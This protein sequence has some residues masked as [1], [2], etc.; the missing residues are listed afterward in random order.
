MKFFT[1]VVCWDEV[2][3]NVLDIEHSFKSNNIPHKIINSG[4]RI[5]DEWLNVGDIRY[6]RQLYKAVQDFDRSYEYMFWLAGDVS[7]NNWISFLDRANLSIS[8]YNVFAYAPHLTSEPWHEGSSRITNLDLDNKMLLSIQTDG[9][10]VI[11]HR[12]VVNML[13]KYFDFL[14][15]KTDITK[16]TSGWGMDMI[17]CAYSIYN[18]KLVL[19][20]NANILNHPSGSSYNHD[21]A[22]HELKIV[23]ETFYEFC[24]ANNIDSNKIKQLHDKIYGRMQHRPDCLSI[25]SFYEAEPDLLKNKYPINYHTIYID[26]TRLTNRNNLDYVLNGNK[27]SI[28]CF[29]AKKDGELDKFK[30]ENPEFKLAWDGFKLGEIG[31]FGSHYLAWKY[32]KQSNLNEL[33]IFEDDV[34]I[35]NSF[36]QKYQTAMSVLPDD[37]DIFS[38]YVDPN[39]YPRFDESQ[40]ISYYIAKGYQ[41]WSTLC[42]VISKR[43]AEKLCK[44]VEEIGFDHPTDWFIFRK[45]HQGIFNVYT[46]PPYIESPLSIDSKYES[47]VQ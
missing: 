30:L 13:E 44:Y 31:N 14:S 16:L 2:Y 36:H 18:K 25:D 15:N 3:N 26:D 33:I 28:K 4:S 43:G 24:D 27:L 6:Y 39:Q 42:Y 5:N 9:I 34:L 12:D 35:D 17:W 23:L 10:A 19:R 41:D 8:T 20:D 37:Y 32:L 29:N 7:Y 46:F 11:L 45:G 38:I 21:K 47:Q 22:S 40:K 1:Y